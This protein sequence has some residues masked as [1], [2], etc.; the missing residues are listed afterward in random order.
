M[1]KKFSFVKRVRRKNEIFSFSF[2][3]FIQRKQNFLAFVF[4]FSIF[5]IVNLR[6]TFTALIF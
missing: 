4:E 6:P 1:A 2:L 3:R 5:Y